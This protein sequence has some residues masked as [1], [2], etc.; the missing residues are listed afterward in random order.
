MCC[1]LLKSFLHSKCV[2]EFILR[3]WEVLDTVRCKPSDV[4]AQ[5]TGTWDEG[6]SEIKIWWQ[7]FQPWT[8][9]TLK[10]CP[11][12]LRMSAL[13]RR[14]QFQEIFLGSREWGRGCLRSA[15]DTQTISEGTASTD[16][17]MS[18]TRRVIHF[19]MTH[20]LVW[21]MSKEMFMPSSLEL[22]QGEICA[23]YKY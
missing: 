4:R 22:V 7:L 23:S 5:V 1:G 17:L 10:G 6:G 9:V 14:T 13:E 8:H 16:S 21:W 15:E 18:V 2:N 12:F 19:G 11:L 3:L 20:E